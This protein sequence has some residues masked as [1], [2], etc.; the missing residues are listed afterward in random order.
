MFPHRNILVRHPDGEPA[1]SLYLTND[2]ARRVIQ[3]N[4]FKRIRLMTAGT[5][6]FTKQEGGFGRNRSDPAESASLFRLL[7]EGLS[8]VLPFIK[9]EAII[10]AEIVVLKV[11][12]QAYYPLTDSFGEEF[13][14][15]MDNK[16]RFK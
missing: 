9:E 5:K 12:I 15:T 16:C 11:F 2:I 3:N 10:D 8:A 13:R 6:I 14:E 1:R 4:D 7:A